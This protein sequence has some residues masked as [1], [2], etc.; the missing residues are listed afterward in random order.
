MTTPNAA[1]LGPT[2]EQWRNLET[3]LSSRLTTLL[4]ELGV[5]WRV[6]AETVQLGEAEVEI[7]LNATQRYGLN[8]RARKYN[9]WAKGQG[10]ALS[11]EFFEARLADD[12]TSL[13]TAVAVDDEG[14]YVEVEDEDEVRFR[15][16]VSDLKKFGTSGQVQ[17]RL[18]DPRQARRET[19]ANEFQATATVEQSVKELGSAPV[20]STIYLDW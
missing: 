11:G 4:S 9:V 2:N 16:S 7:R 19:R 6:V 15:L 1:T 18:K 17:T 14:R 5:D 8:N 3:V 13:V 20:K 12:S 10:L